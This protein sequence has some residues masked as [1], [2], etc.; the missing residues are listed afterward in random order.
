MRSA[1]SWKLL[2]KLLDTLTETAEYKML[3]MQ[4]GSKRQLHIRAADE[5]PAVACEAKRGQCHDAVE[6]ASLQDPQHLL[7]TQ[8]AC[9]YGATLLN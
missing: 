5:A 3:R 9:F 6:P 4:Q 7:A 8:A 1:N 2:E